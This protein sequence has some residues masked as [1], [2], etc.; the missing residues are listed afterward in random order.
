MDI[1]E[2]LGHF[3]GALLFARFESR[4]SD[5]VRATMQ[6]PRY[7]PSNVSYVFVIVHMVYNSKQSFRFMV[8]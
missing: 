4:E 3:G 2:D 6:Q 1:S 8:V 7:L 5:T